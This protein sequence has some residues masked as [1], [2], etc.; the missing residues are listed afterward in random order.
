MLIALAAAVASVAHAAQNEID[1]L[2]WLE[3]PAGERAVAWARETTAAS[4]A[5][6]TERPSYRQTLRDLRQALDAAPVVPDVA[7]LGPYAVRFQRD[8]KHPK[9]LLQRADRA[10][11]TLGAWRTVLDVDELSRREGADYD[12][13]WASDRCLAPAFARC[14]LSFGVAGGD[15]AVLREFD[16]AAGRFVAG[17][18]SLPVSQHVVAWINTDAIVIGHDLAGAPTTAALWPAEAYL[19]RRG[20]SLQASRKLFTAAPTDAL[21]QLYPLGDGRALL[22]QTVDFSTY[23]LHVIAADGTTTRLSLPAKLKPFGFQ[24]ATARHLFVQLGE[25]ATCEGVRIPAESI[26]SYDYASDGT[27]RR[28]VAIVY[29]PARAEVISSLGFATTRTRVLFP[30]S[31]NMKVRLLS[32]RHDG[33]HWRVAP[34][35]RAEAGV[36]I[37]IT[38]ADPTGEDVAMLKEGFLLPPSLELLRENGSRAVIERSPPAFDAPRHAVEVRQARAPDGELIDYLLIVPKQRREPVPTL[39]T[40]YGAFGISLSPAY[41]TTATGQF[42]GGATL[43]LWLQHAGALVVPAIRGGGERG[44]AWHR[45]AMGENRQRSYDDFLAVASDLMHLGVTDRK[46][47]GVFGTSNGG[48]L[49]AVVGLQ[50]PDLFSAVVADAPLTDMLRFTE[51]GAGAAWTAEYGD[52]KDPRAAAWLTRYSPLHNVRAGVDYPPFFISVAATDNRVGP[53]HARKLAKRL[54]DVNAKVFYLEAAAGGHDVSDPLLRPE[55]MAMRATFLFDRLFPPPASDEFVNWAQSRAVPLSDFATDG[56]STEAMRDL[57]GSAR[58]VALGEPAHGAHEPLAFRNQ[59]L[60]HLVEKLGFTAIAL[61][62]GL[63]EARRANDFV[64]GGPGDAREIARHGLTWGFG[65]Y[66]ENVQLLR[67]LRQYN[68]ESPGSKVRFY[69]IDLS[70]AS[71][72][73]FTTARVALDDSL[74]YLDRIA[75]DASRRERTDL[76]PFV[77]RFTRPKYLDL[78]PAEKSQLHDAIARLIAFF[79]RERPRLIAASSAD[80]FAWAQRS[81]VVAGQLEQLFRLWPADMPADSVSAEFQEAAAARDTAMADNVQWALGRE[82]AAGRMLVYAHNA[83]VMNAKVRGGIWSVYQQPPV[84]MGQHLRA[85]LGKDLAIIATLSAR[86]DAGLPQATANRTSLEGALERVGAAPFLLDLR[87][88]RDVREVA[89]WLTGLQSMRANFTTQMLVSPQDAFDALVFVEPLT[90]A[91]K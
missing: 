37:R 13:R 73:N 74:A 23:I 29:T 57:V 25:T 81:A 75:R 54:A 82:G 85:A 62:T 40:G 55:M 19:W 79:A 72:G 47:L 56:A 60:V 16:L 91:G 24:G 52:P 77:S 48:L 36:D 59:L 12:L 68:A 89:P 32:A 27:D 3:A 80:D 33:R 9:G 90:P 4:T 67:W 22:A 42:Y 43:Q 1:Q 46:H 14:L 28:R 64:L 31:A 83:H 87:D 7:L 2:R 86:N 15:Q 44:E 76:E 45:A 11:G 6:L 53:G 71:D 66:S 78:A 8:A 49:A 26:I 51:M 63:S 58:V 84:A 39:M 50:R 35:E 69:G 70:G 38:G 41:P 18:F 20:T 88:A 5:A 17:G 30:V 10:H 34:V 61:E 65:E 21:F